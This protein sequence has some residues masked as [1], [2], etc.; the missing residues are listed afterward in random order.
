MSTRRRR[1]KRDTPRHYG[2]LGLIGTLAL[3]GAVVISYRANSG[4]PFQS[5]YRMFVDVPNADRL[6]HYADVR[7]G[8]IRVGQ[9]QSIVAEPG[10]DAAQPFSRLELSLSPSVGRLPIDSR[11]QIRSASVLGATYV[12]LTPGHSPRKLAPG[13][14]LPITQVTSTVQLTDLLDV[15]DHATASSIQTVLGGLGE[16]LAG[17]GDDL[18]AT[19]ASLA[20]A[21]QP[22]TRVLGALAS[23]RAGLARF[24]SGY[25]ATVGALAPVAGPLGSLFADAATTLGAL[26][27]ARGPLGQTIDALP[28]AEAATTTALIDLEPGISGLARLARDLRP[29]ADLLGST[30]PALNRTLAAG[31]TP[32]GQLPALARELRTALDALDTVARDPA[33]SGTVRQLTAAISAVKLLL[34]ALTPAQ[35]QCNILGIYGQNLPSALAG[36]GTAGAPLA[37]VGVTSLGAKNEEFQNATPS[38]NMHVD[39]NPIENYQQCQAGNEPYNTTTQVLSNPPG[40]LSNQTEPT[41]PPPG[42]TALAAKAGLLNTPPGTP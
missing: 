10:H 7:I 23:P 28:P 5:S 26:N 41:Y 20:G 17:R 18:N 12:D 6:N 34:D 1:R 2:L 33:A 38:P 29:G 15:F 19:I 37:E 24:L 9:V 4:L 25:E 30:L 21:A 3:L 13:G 35:L 36:T 8:G 42:V 16:G 31:V 11:V 27:A 32:L 40:V 22:L 14:T 39:A